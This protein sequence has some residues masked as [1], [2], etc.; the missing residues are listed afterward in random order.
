M[1]E[2]DLK[3]TGKEIKGFYSLIL[4]LWQI[5]DFVRTTLYSSLFIHLPSATSNHSVREKYFRNAIYVEA[6]KITCFFFIYFILEHIWQLLDTHSKNSDCKI[7]NS[8]EYLQ[9]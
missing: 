5:V 4:L 2:R 8:I 9:V 1:N 7:F 3:L 6:V